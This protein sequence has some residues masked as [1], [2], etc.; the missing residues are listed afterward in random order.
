VF[1]CGFVLF[2][3]A[4]VVQ[5]LVPA[6]IR[7][8][9]VE[10]DDA[11]RYLAQAQVMAACIGGDCPALA[12]VQAQMVGGKPD[13]SVAFHRLRTD[14]HLFTY[15]HPLF[16]QVLSGLR[17]FGL[18]APQAYAI[19]S[20]GLGAMLCIAV[21]LW[22][23][24]VWGRV[25]AGIALGLLAF[26][27]LPGK[28]LRFVPWALALGWAALSWAVIIRARRELYPFVPLLWIAALATHSMGL[29]YM[30]AGLL[31]LLG[32]NGLH[33]DRQSRWLFL[34]GC[35]VILVRLVMAAALPAFALSGDVEQFFAVEPT[36][37]EAWTAGALELA[38]LIA[39]WG[40]TFWRLPAAAL[41][42][43]V[44]LAATPRM[45]RR[46]VAVTGLSL[47]GVLLLS[48]VYYHPVHGSTAIGRVWP[49]VA[50]FL[51]GAIG[52]TIAVGARAAGQWRSGRR[53]AEAPDRRWVLR[54]AALAVLAVLLGRALLTTLRYSA[55]ASRGA[56][57][58]AIM[59]DNLDLGGAEANL[60]A[61]NEV[62][63]VVYLD[64]LAL[65]H[66]LANSG[67]DHEA[68]YPA[69]LGDE[70]QKLEWLGGNPRLTHAVGLSPLAGLPE[71]WRGA[72]PITD[73]RTL[74]ILGPDDGSAQWSALKVENLGGEA[75]LIFNPRVPA[76]SASLSV[77]VPA[78]FSGWVPLPAGLEQASQFTLATDP[79]TDL[80]Y[81]QG[82]RVAGQGNL[83]W[84]WNR[85]VRL[86]TPDPIKPSR[87]VE[88]ALD[89]SRMVGDLGLNLEVVSDENTLVLARILR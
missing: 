48:T 57:V 33:L 8:E 47:V 62:G 39:R 68:V 19:A 30:A 37:L 27:Q 84:P 78:G 49:G 67:L 4:R 34:A 41:L 83:R 81:I 2:V 73:D 32:I 71:L 58:R 69:I 70:E 26:Y 64:E 20:I 9:P 17:D 88:V 16:S 35:L 25:P 7:L 44:G 52:N 10:I 22:M 46:R 5:S 1:W 31:M 87:S 76:A 13:R 72:I 29:F 11:Y 85:G 80:L 56:A 42:A 36:W 77:S 14:I 61:A 86:R 3:A 51:V 60:W 18:A 28:E 63:A 54:G 55:T 89:T 6:A 15:F 74:E 50:F 24:A 21:G 66:S 12:A 59:K 23:G 79:N 43:V 75:T 82:L 65:Y 45:S 53:R 40:A 38:D